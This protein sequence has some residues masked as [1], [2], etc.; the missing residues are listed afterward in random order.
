MLKVIDIKEALAL[1][2]VLFIDVRSQSEYDDGTI[3]GSV[4]IPILD[5]AERVIIGTIYRKKSPDEATLEGLNFASNKL[6]N[7]YKKIKEYSKKYDNIVI[8]CW[9]GGMRSTSVCTLL[10]MLKISNI[11]RLTGGYKNYR[12]YVIDFLKNKIDRYKFVMLHGLTG[13]GKTHI[14][15]KLQCIGKPVLNLEKIAKNSGSVFGNIVF[16]GKPPTQKMFESLIFNVLY[17]AEEDYIFVES[18]SK[19]IGSVQI[20]EAVYNRMINGYHILLKTTLENRIKIILEDYVVH[21]EEND[22]KIMKSINHLRKRLGNEAVDKLIKKI[23]TKDYTYVVKYL[24]EYYYDPLYKYSIKKYNNYDIVIDYD[25]INDVLPII[26]SFLNN[27]R[28]TRRELE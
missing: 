3:P 15:E 8:F 16:S 9:R 21:L 6:P 25:D 27:I 10:S 17:K 13:V 11:Y 20:P 4:N 1:K 26:N 23:D 5:D 12:K 19:R 24:M 18:E 7:L 28:I 2:N 14:L 22:F